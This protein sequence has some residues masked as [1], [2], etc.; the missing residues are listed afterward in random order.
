MLYFELTITEATYLPISVAACILDD[1]ASL[2]YVSG[3]GGMLYILREDGF[4]YE[5]LGTYPAF[6]RNHPVYGIEIC[7]ESCPYYRLSCRHGWSYGVDVILS[8]PDIFII[9]TYYIALQLKEFEHDDAFDSEIIANCAPVPTSSPTVE[10]T[11]D[12]TRNPTS[13]PT[14]EPT[15]N[16]TLDPTTTPTTDPTSDPILNP[17]Y[18]P[19][20]EPTS[21]PT[22]TP[23]Y[24]PT[25]EP[26][27][28]PT[29]SPTYDPTIEPTPSPTKE[30]SWPI[31]KEEF[32][33]VDTL[34][35][36]S[37]SHISCGQTLF[38]QEN[39]DNKLVSY[40]KFN[41]TTDLYPISYITTCLV[42]NYIENNNG[43][44][45]DSEIYIIRANNALQE[46]HSDRATCNSQSAQIEI[47]SLPVGVYFAVVQGY[48]NQIG[49]FS[50]SMHCTFPPPKI[51]RELVMGFVFGICGGMILIFSIY[52]FY[53]W[54]KHCKNHKQCCYSDESDPKANSITDG[55]Q[56][57]NSF[58]GNV[59]ELTA[60]TG[61]TR[62]T[63]NNL[64]TST[65]HMSL[66]Q[67]EDYL[68]EDDVD[69]DYVEDN[70]EAH[71]CFCWKVEWETKVEKSIEEEN[72]EPGDPR[73]IDND[74]ELIEQLAEGEDMVQLTLAHAIQCCDD[75]EGLDIYQILAVRYFDIES[76]RISGRRPF[77][78]IG[79][80]CEII[81]ISPFINAA[82][83]SIIVGLAQTI[84][85]T[86]VIWKILYAYFDGL[87]D[88]QEMC[89]MDAWRWNEVYSLKMLSFLLSLIIAFYVSIV[90]NN[91]QHS[92]LY[93]MMDRLKPQHLVRLDRVV[94]W[95]LQMGEF[96]NYYVCLLVVIGSYFIIFE[97]NT[98][99]EN[100]DGTIDYSHSGLD[101]IL[102]A[103]ALFFMLELDDL[104][105]SAQDYNDC[106]EHLQKIRMCYQ[107]DTNINLQY[108]ANVGSET[109]CCCCCKRKT[110]I[111]KAN[112]LPVIKEENDDEEKEDNQMVKIF[113][114]NDYK[115]WNAEE[116]VDWIV[117]L[118]DNFGQKYFD[119]LKHVFQEKG[120]NGM[121]FVKIKKSELLSWGIVDSKDRNQIYQEI[122]INF[123]NHN[124]ICL[125]WIV[126]YIHVL[127]NVF[128]VFVK[129]LCYG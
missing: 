13:A 19:T 30:Y 29:R 99:E 15:S 122:R 110:L 124:N 53:E 74:Q 12:P 85:I 125:K 4:A 8:D 22:R 64:N 113:D 75:G 46:A 50:I 3:S 39:T 78:K 35:A 43:S 83:V 62:N 97:S 26:T 92:G 24:G 61:Q 118:D 54:R 52:Y 84:G 98:G 49:S 16:P 128:S 34:N 102:N 108:G 17:T 23:T 80:N 9:G 79:C 11:Y 68:D 86:V 106:K 129:L 111:E 72:I 95:I 42:G 77:Q 101:M 58:S 10:P 120:I 28:D 81:A 121:Y 66:S 45:Y 119:D 70:L 126:P 94:L 96:I 76:R 103:V 56:R 105:V 33:S 55:H 1:Q 88:D 47:N 36:D 73:R 60:G 59:I 25:I 51:S 41:I 40:Y 109:V 116:C 65:G 7:D 37:Y 69:E 71:C 44:I 100:N 20:I 107:P 115:N 82:F 127:L 91:M 117:S 21:D 112:K 104:M 123:K 5:I 48:D 57:T 14:M 67:N 2:A 87:E 6:V 38:E 114:I 18:G 63:I 93:E 89:V 27:Y 90:L 31:K 32:L